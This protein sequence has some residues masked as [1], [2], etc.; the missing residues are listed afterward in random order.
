MLAVNVS[1]L[2]IPALGSGSGANNPTPPSTRNEL[3]AIIA[4]YIS[5]A[6]VLGSML[7]S[8][9]LSSQLDRIDSAPEVVC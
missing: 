9:Q 2:A 3:E 1:L 4:I 6:F 8:I 5:I 7:T